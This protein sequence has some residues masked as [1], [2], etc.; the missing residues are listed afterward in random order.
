MSLDQFPSCEQNDRIT[1][2]I[3]VLVV[4]DHPL[5]RQELQSLVS[6]S[7]DIKIIGEAIDGEQACELAQR[8]QPDVILMDIEM[9][10]MNGIDA[11]RWIKTALPQ[12]IIIG[13][14]S[15]KVSSSRTR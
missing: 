1:N 10:T 4:D 15:I 7:G 9:P 12:I 6:C 5:L 11:T 2:P 3:H 14:P 13:S 8:L